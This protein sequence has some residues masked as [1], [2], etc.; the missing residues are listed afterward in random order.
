MLI[1][2]MDKILSGERFIILGWFIK[3][4]SAVLILSA[5]FLSIDLMAQSLSH[6]GFGTAQDGVS[7]SSPWPD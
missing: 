3:I 2:I 7:P 6:L 4:A 5:F 1:I